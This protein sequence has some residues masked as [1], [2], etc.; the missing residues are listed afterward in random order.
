M[1]IDNNDYEDKIN[2]NDDSNDNNDRNAF[3]DY[4]FVLSIEVVVIVIVQYST[5]TA[6][7]F[8][9][10]HICSHLG[11]ILRHPNGIYSSSALSFFFSLHKHFREIKIEALGKP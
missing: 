2:D 10:L 11:C 4:H 3:H 8:I 7:H 6:L 1:I 9:V 5:C